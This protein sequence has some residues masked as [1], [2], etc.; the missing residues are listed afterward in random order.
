MAVDRWDLEVDLVAVGSGIGGLAAAITAHDCG[1]SAVVLEKAGLLGGVTAY[2]MGEVWIG[3]NHLQEEAG[4]ADSV[5]ETITYLKWLGAHYGQEELM[6]NFVETAPK[7]LQYFTEKAGLRLKI[8]KDFSDYYYP[9]GE[10]SKPEGRFLEPEPFPGALLGEWASKTRMS[11]LMPSGITHDEMF[12]WGNAANLR[13]WN[14]ELYGQRVAEDIRTFGPALAAYFVKAALNRGI[15]LHLETPAIALIRDGGRVIGVRAQKNGRDFLVRARRG[16]VLATG[17]YDWNREMA[18][19]YEQ[20]PEWNSSCPP[21]VTGDHLVMAGEVGAIVASVPAVGLP[22]ML[23]MNV[24]GEEHD[25]VPLFRGV[26]TEA[27]LPHA[28]LVNKQ[29]H[30]FADE[31]FYRAFM[32]A[33]RTF[34]GKTQSYPNWPCFII[35]D[36]NHRD[37]YPFCAIGPGKPLPEGFAVKADS[38][39]ELADRLGIDREGLEETVRRY[40][41]YARDGYDPEFSRGSYPWA[42]TFDGDM[43]VKPN[44][45]MAPLEKPPFWGVRPTIT[46]M[47]INAAGLKV[48]THS[49]VIN[50]RGEPIP[51]LYAAGNA[52]AFLDIGAGYQSGISNARGMVQGYQAALHA[53]GR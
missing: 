51:G 28:I 7:A 39:G 29:G 38:I 8:I 42:N 52:V 3:A 53:A 19:Y 22:A 12:S 9:T 44:P 15:P 16:V 35:F 11:P 20:L 13:G 33:V 24:P 18:H 30:R 45:N 14:W 1:L 43:K 26:I 4:L 32:T 27:G 36:Q 2:S 47:G 34:D 25:G 21:E 49:Q 6:R 40:N 37:K 23:G 41:Q 5:E 50:L 48:N 46:G 31:S 10:C 17:G